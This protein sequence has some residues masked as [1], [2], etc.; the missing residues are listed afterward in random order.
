MYNVYTI[1]CKIEKT[2]FK[3]TRYCIP[4]LFSHIGVIC[5]KKKVEIKKGVFQFYP[6]KTILYVFCF[7]KSYQVS[8]I[9]QFFAGHL[10]NKENK[11]SNFS[12][13][14]SRYTERA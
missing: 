12:R 11:W 9:P 13:K 4:T 1:P 5:G 8:P 3:L 14:I 6:W 10:E 7:N 2:N